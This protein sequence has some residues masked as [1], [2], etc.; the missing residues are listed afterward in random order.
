MK[1]MFQALLNVDD[2][3]GVVLLSLKGDLVQSQVD[4]I[5]DESIASVDW[6]QIVQSMNNA[7]EVVLVFKNW[8][9]YI[10]KTAIGI[11]MVVLG[12]FAVMAMV[13]LTC[14]KF[15]GRQAIA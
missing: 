7:H 12:W 14:D 4:G 10:R 15:T 11:V 6:H 2:V 3:K 8:R 1:E 13:R 5:P 9:I